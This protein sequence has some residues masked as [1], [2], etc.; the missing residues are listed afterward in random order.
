VCPSRPVMDTPEM[1]AVHRGGKK[2]LAHYET[3]IEVHGISS[4]STDKKRR[5]ED[6]DEIESEEK[7]QPHNNISREPQ[8][9][10][11][12]VPRNVKRQKILN[13]DGSV[14]SKAGENRS[15]FGQQPTS[16]STRTNQNIPKSTSD[17]TNKL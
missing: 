8:I 7:V 14:N 5:R 2:H 1:L 12:M 15:G 13:N 4:T 10:P 9:G 11:T 16:L 6:D 17:D 3:Y